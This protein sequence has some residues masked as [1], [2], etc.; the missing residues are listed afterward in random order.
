MFHFRSRSTCLVVG[1]FLLAIAGNCGVGTTTYA[2]AISGHS[3]TP[4][5]FKELPAK[6][7]VE[8]RAGSFRMML[9]SDKTEQKADELTLGR[10]GALM[11]P[12][13]EVT[14]FERGQDATQ[15]ATLPENRAAEWMNQASPLVI[16]STPTSVPTYDRYPIGFS[17]QPLY[18]EDCDLE[19][20]GRGHA[21]A[22][23]AVSSFRFL[24]DTV[25][26]PLR[27]IKQPAWECVP[28]GVDCKTCEKCSD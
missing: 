9:A 15:D 25:V 10:L 17:H 20:C 4:L 13:R 12:L 18:F 28:H 14:L 27:L 1:S 24:A 7:P 21:C 5:S 23:N 3:S 8:N 11:K 22:T 16:E 6:I 2:Q 19:R 26:L